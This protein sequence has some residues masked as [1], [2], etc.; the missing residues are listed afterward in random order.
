M[1]APFPLR[2]AAGRAGGTMSLTFPSY[3]ALSVAAAAAVFGHATY[4]HRYLYRTVVHLASSKVA[5]L[6]RLARGRGLRGG[7]WGGWTLEGGS[8]L[9]LAA[10]GGGE[11][12]G[13]HRAVW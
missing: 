3:L 2:E 13:C 10:R 12:V 9:A 6:V 5:T 7:G 8:P 1:P 4:M 11:R